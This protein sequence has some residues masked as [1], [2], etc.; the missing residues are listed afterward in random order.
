MIDK[1]TSFRGASYNNEHDIVLHYRWEQNGEKYACAIECEDSPH[2]IDFAS[3]QLDQ[4][5]ARLVL[6]VA[7]GLA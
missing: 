4:M 6:D 1:F 7:T 5:F 2:A 3:A